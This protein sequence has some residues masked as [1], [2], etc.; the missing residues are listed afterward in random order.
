M[1]RQPRT[2]R[3]F[4]RGVDLLAGAIRPTLGP[5]PRNTAVE[6]VGPRPH[7][8][9]LLDSG[10]L[11][12]RRFLQVRERDA[13]VG[14]MFLRQMLWR[15]HERVGDGTATAAVVFQAL[16]RQGV[17]HVVAGG[18]AMRLR[19]ALERGMLVVLDALAGQAQ[20]LDS[21]ASVAHLALALC[22]DPPLADALADILETVGPHGPVDIRSGRSQGIERQYIVGS[23]YR[24]RPLSEWQLAGSL[25]RRIDVVS[26]ALVLS[27]LDLDDPADLAPL[28][29]LVA[30]E[31]LGSLLLLARR[32]SEACLGVLNAAGPACRVLVVRAPD[33]L[34]GQDAMLDDLGFLTGARVLRRAAGDSIRRVRREDLGHARRAWSD[35]EHI[36]VIGGRGPAAALRIHLMHLRQAHARAEQA[37]I[38]T[39]LGERIGKLQGG[40]AVLWVGGLGP[41]D[42]AERRERANRTLSALRA[43]IGRGVVPGGGAALLACAWQLRARAVD[44][45]DSDEAAAQRM[46]ARA[47]E[48]PAR[49]IIHNAGYDPVPLVHAIARAGA[50]HGFDVRTGQ[51]VDLRVAGI[52]DPLG[53]VHAAL[54][55]AIA[56]AALALTVDVLVHQRLPELSFEP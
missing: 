50:G 35:D 49:V 42:I 26:P 23:W 36:G 16:Y 33:A 29:R 53:V 8:P 5:V 54:H 38:R 39:R 27:D 21:R 43:T 28:L 6:P 15:L 51:V 7:L 17:R 25:A 2:Y 24:S 10:G 40:S 19:R 32:A 45:D 22:H 30:R 13:D 9:E 11:I 3:G 20:P 48:E 52:I 18:D 14:A 37:D 1:T 34:H 41:A 56:S 55:S 44:A 47:L 4:G 12:A 46:L 31:Q